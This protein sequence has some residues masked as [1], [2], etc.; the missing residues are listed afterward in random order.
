MISNLEKIPSVYKDWIGTN[1]QAELLKNVKN[2][3]LKN[4]I[5]QL[6][7]E[8]SFI[9]DGGTADVLA[10]ENSTG[11]GLGKNGGTHFQK[12]QDMVSYVQNKILTQD[13]SVGDRTIADSL[14]KDLLNALGGN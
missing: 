11:L 3:K 14:L 10:F 8:N 4:A 13:L 12:A 5:K 7:R 9:G 2:P 6:Y 1:K